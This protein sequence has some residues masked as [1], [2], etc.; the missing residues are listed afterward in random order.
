MFGE[1]VEEYL[2]GFAQSGF[3]PDKIAELREASAKSGVKGFYQKLLEQFKAGPQTEEDHVLIAE[4]HARLG[5]KE[6]AF[7][8]LEKA[9]AERADGLAHLKENLGFDNLRS[10]PRYADLLQRIGLP[11]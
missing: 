6:Q 4:L 11:Q 1:A 5:E 8:W 3:S 7:E 9:Y 2:K 10:D